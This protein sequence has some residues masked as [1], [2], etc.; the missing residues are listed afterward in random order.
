MTI[1]LCQTALLRTILASYRMTLVPDVLAGK[2][3]EFSFQ[4]V[5]LPK[6]SM[7]AEVC[8]INLNFP[9]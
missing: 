6:L 9:N 1:F 2:L 4:G 7:D 3:Y 8:N 5:Y